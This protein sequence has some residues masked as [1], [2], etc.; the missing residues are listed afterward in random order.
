MA[1]PQGITQVQLKAFQLDAQ[2]HYSFQW[3]EDQPNGS[4]GYRF[5]WQAGQPFDCA[6]LDRF[7]QAVLATSS[8]HTRSSHS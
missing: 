5:H 3:F 1:A 6:E 4:Q 2:Q 7:A 8:V